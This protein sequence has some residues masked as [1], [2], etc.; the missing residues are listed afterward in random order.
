M[1]AS[2]AIGGTLQYGYNLAIMNSPTVVSSFLQQYVSQCFLVL[3]IHSNLDK[4]YKVY[5]LIDRVEKTE[6]CLGQDVHMAH[7]L[8][9]RINK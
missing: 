4:V 3:I 8:L 1:V 9:L 6:G 2:A 7:S 5:L